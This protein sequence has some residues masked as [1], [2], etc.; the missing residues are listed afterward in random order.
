MNKQGFVCLVLAGIVVMGMVNAKA[1]VP[2]WENEQIIGI[3]K[4]APR[5]TSMP[6][7]DIRSA[8]TGDRLSSRWAKL[9][10]GDW[11]FHWSPDP[12]SRP[13]D[14]YRPDYDVRD[15]DTI[16]VPSNWQME[17]YGVPLYS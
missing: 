15:W 16:P 1:D 12:D 3:N 14:F 8:V 7:P 2:D 10:N 13:A 9:L 17:G 6:Y 4:E 11:K 5:S